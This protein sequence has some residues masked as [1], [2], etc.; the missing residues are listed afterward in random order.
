[1]NSLS[2]VE[3]QDSKNYYEHFKEV[4]L[5]NKSLPC[6]LF[7]HI[8]SYLNDRDHQHSALVNRLWNKA[9]I[10]V[11]KRQEFSNINHFIQFLADHLNKET[12]KSL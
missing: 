1:M 3:R 6:E 2:D 11:A 5:I 10:D 4:D 9:T 12:D 7:E 8:L